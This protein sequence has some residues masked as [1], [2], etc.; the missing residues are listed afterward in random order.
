MGLV[1][2]DYAWEILEPHHDRLLDCVENSWTQWRSV[3]RFARVLTPQ[4]RAKTMRE[5]FADQADKLFDHVPGVHVRNHP[6]GLLSFGTLA[7][8][9]LKELD[10]WM[11]PESK[12]TQLEFPMQTSAQATFPAVPGVA[13]VTIGYILSPTASDIKTVCATLLVRTDPSPVDT[14]AS[15]HRAKYRPHWMYEITRRGRNIIPFPAKLPARD[16]MYER[17]R[18][19]ARESEQEDAA[20]RPSPESTKGKS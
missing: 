11:L 20:T 3:K 16:T 17:V 4:L 14:D 10:A 5:F 13:R 6:K 12:I 19:P 2:K 8:T 1:S 9:S 18:P 7:I 15:P